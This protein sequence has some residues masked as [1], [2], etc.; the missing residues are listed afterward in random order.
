[1]LNKETNDLLT[2]TN[3]ETPGGD[4]MRRYWQPV[5][6]SEEMTTGGAPLPVDIMGEELVLFRDD[7]GRLGLLDR[8]CC[9]RGSDISY[10]RVEDGGLRC[11]YHGWLFDVEGK[12]MEQPAEPADSTFKDKV[13]QRAYP[14]I[15]RAGA[16]FAYMGP[17]DAPLL[18]NYAF[19][20]APDGHV[21]MNKLYQECNYLQ[22]N[23]SNIDPT[24]TEYLHRPLVAVEAANTPGID[25]NFFSLVREHIQDLVEIEETS[26]GVR[27][28]A[29]R[30]LGE[31]RKFLRVTNFVLPNLCAIAGSESREDPEGS[32][33]AHWHVPINDH[34]HW[35]FEFKYQRNKPVDRSYYRRMP[36]IELGDDF[37][38]KRNLANRYL[39]DRKAQKTVNYTGMGDWFPTHDAYA[40]ET[41]GPI[42]DRTEEHLGTADIAIAA[43][44]RQLLMGINEIGAGGDP[45]HVVRAAADNDFS[46]L[47]VVSQVVD[48]DTDIYEYAMGKAREY[49]E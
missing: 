35:R 30:H 37:R 5:A 42:Q 2:R 21:H 39:Q 23:E 24:H 26:F 27:I 44:R 11:L 20:N 22:G 49:A 32:F 40:S 8:H 17:G 29:V 1:M 9:H 47:V 18:P 6:L 10:G 48:E 15:E 19:L 16:V 31:G 33:T 7:E 41:M 46:H 34:T 3:R 14:C 28:F 45:L 4:M 38:L 43:A 36:D 12:C 13:H 25:R